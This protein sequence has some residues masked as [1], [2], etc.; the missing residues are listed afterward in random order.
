MQCSRPTD[1]VW[2]DR[3][4]T[5][6]EIK[7]VEDFYKQINERLIE[8]TGDTDQNAKINEAFEMLRDVISSVTPDAN[9]ENRWGTGPFSNN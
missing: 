2:E 3:Y 5:K 4:L 9:D 8:L 1:A 7:Q 6:D